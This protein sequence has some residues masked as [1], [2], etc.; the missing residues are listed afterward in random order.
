[1]TEDGNGSLTATAAD[2]DD[3][4]ECR[5]CHHD[6]DTCAFCDEPDCPSPICYTDLSSVL[7]LSSPLI[8]DHGG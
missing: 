3:R 1:M 6:I 4:C 8:H 2:V 5:D 7:R